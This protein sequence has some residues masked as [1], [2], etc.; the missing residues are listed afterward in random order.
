[1]FL[2]ATYQS[3]LLKTNSMIHNFISFNYIVQRIKDVAEEYGIKTVEISEYK[4]STRCIKCG[5]ENTICTGRFFKCVE[6]GLEANRDTVGVLNMANLH[7]EG[8]ASGVIAY[9]LFLRWDGMRWEG[10]SPMNNKS[11]KI[12]EAGIQQASAVGMSTRSQSLIR[13][14]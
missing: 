7:H 8:T 3:K 11:M 6:C 14:A 1:M 13:E 12:L 9:S 5:L 4:T 2:I 10:K